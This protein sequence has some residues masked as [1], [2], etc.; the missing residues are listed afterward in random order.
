MRTC[1]VQV[2]TGLGFTYLCF[3]ILVVIQLIATA[4][5]FKVARQNDVALRNTICKMI[6]YILIFSTI[7]IIM[8]FNLPTYGLYAEAKPDLYDI[9]AQTFFFIAVDGALLQPYFLYQLYRIT[10]TKSEKRSGKDNASFD[11]I[12]LHMMHESADSSEFHFGTGHASNTISSSSYGRDSSNTSKRWSNYDDRISLMN[13]AAP[14]FSPSSQDDKNTGSQRSASA[15][16]PK[17]D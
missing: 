12:N 1:R 7:F 8:I 11:Q 16:S 5:I 17:S 6:A 13:K 4:L 14:S 3:L 2:Y 15:K 9:E 10:H